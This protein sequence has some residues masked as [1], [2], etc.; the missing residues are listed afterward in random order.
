MKT[1]RLLLKPISENDKDRLFSLFRKET[2]EDYCHKIECM[3]QK[4]FTAG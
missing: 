4:L 1:E 2:I 3:Q